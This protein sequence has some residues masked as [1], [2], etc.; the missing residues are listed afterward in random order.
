MRFLDL[1]V[2]NFRGFGP[3]AETIKFGG[4]LI[5]MFGPNGFGKTSISEAV[6]W[7]FYG[8]T[9]RRKRG[10]Q[11]SRPEYANS[12][13]NVH[14]R[15][16]VEV[17]ATVEIAGTQHVL[18]RRLGPGET[19]VTSVDGVESSFAVL[20][21][22]PIEAV[23]PV[24]AQHGLQTFILSKPKDRRDAISAALGLD[25]LTA[26][27]ASLE[28]ARSSFQRTPPA[29]VTS[30]RKELSGLA[31]GLLTVLE[32]ND[33][34]KRWQK[35]PVEV[36]ATRDPEQLLE[37]ARALSHSTAESV[38]DVLKD[39]RTTRERAS[40]ALFDLEGFSPLGGKTAR[41]AIARAV[42]LEKLLD[43]LSRGAKNYLEQV[44]AGYSAALLDFWIKGIELAPVGEKCPMCESQTLRA[45]HREE[46]AARIK[47]GADQIQTRKDLGSVVKSIAA[48]A[49]QL[50]TDL[51]ALAIPSDFSM[52]EDERLREI[53]GHGHGAVD[54]FS[55]AHAD[56]RRE[57]AG[58]MSALL[59]VKKHASEFLEK[60]D[61]GGSF[62]AVLSAHEIARNT[63]RP[64]ASRSG[65]SS[66][67]YGAAFD[68]L[69]ALIAEKVSSDKE[70][71]K[72]DAVGK[73]LRK[74][75]QVDLLARYATTLAESLELIR[76]VEKE[77]QGKHNVLLN[78]RGQEV[79]DFYD[80]LNVGA[81]VG[82]SGMEPGNDSMQLH[83]TSFGRKMSAAANLSECQLNCLG[84]ATY[85]MRACSPGT[86]FGFVLL[87]DPVQSMDDGHAES[88]IAD[89]VPHLLDDHGKQV[90]VLSHTQ[91][92]IE[93]LRDLNQHR[94]TRV[95]HLDNY[96]K[97]GPTLTE[98]VGLQMLISEIKGGMVGNE[99]NR[100]YAIDRIRVLGEEVIRAIYLKQMRSP[101]PAKYDRANPSDLLDLFRT[102]TG[103]SQ[104]EYVGLRDTMRFADPA[105]HTQV[106][107]AVPVKTNIQPHLDRL[108]GLIKTYGI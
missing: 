36:D 54:A 75:D 83:A 45:H 96:E 49:S 53:L 68:T 87:D 17:I 2:R 63:I 24:I 12:Y 64:A 80:R 91:K 73:A 3:S 33:V 5:L 28:G 89:I 30:A 95:Y 39:L 27:K 31:P 32:A 108:G 69:D 101:A 51:R 86:P 19:S 76:S 99:K 29:N 97:D 84:L 70:V 41:L 52:V 34:S 79:K 98:Q 10:E 88:F 74:L 22:K 105:H 13:A 71:A 67:S 94:A 102:I 4:D 90:I 61:A 44:A 60:L 15:T 92:V 11:F 57:L 55:V 85:L 1:T 78:T 77:I 103:T 18:S 6:E 46:L 8:V 50:E 59:S 43:T 100:E 107:Y 65:R 58:A 48:L 42:R 82:F 25:E 7:L 81:D 14:G 93:R 26:F 62:S 20:G 38:E 56:F 9:K 72:I 66:G 16:P 106:G 104:Q 23:Y 47:A 37:A 21:H 35:Q 40:K